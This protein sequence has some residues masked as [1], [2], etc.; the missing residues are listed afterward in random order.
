MKH[1]YMSASLYTLATYLWIRPQISGFLLNIV[2]QL[3]GSV[4]II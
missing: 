3:L 1:H 4:R 2:S